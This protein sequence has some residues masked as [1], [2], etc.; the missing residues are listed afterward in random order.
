[1]LL[2]HVF[3]TTLSSSNLHPSPLLAEAVSPPVSYP[4]PRSG[5]IPFLPR[6]P[7]PTAS[8]R[9]NVHL[10]VLSLREPLDHRGLRNVATATILFLSLKVNILKAQLIVHPHL[11]IIGREL[12]RIEALAGSEACC[13]T[14]LML[15]LT[16]TG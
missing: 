4:P 2:F 5:N 9:P 6:P 1:M 13:S 8:L 11:C 7:S 3:L 15:M 14:Q 16:I 10:K 12:C